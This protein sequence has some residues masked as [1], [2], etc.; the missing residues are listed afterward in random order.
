MNKSKGSKKR[1]ESAEKLSKQIPR[2]KTIALAEV[3]GFPS[4]N[5]EQAKKAFRDKADFIYINK[6]VIYNALKKTSQELADKVYL[7]K[8][9]VLVLS[10]LDAFELARI[11][12][13][14]KAYAK[15]K[16]GEKAPEDIILPSGPTP[17]PPGPML[18]Q[19]SS[20]GVKTKNEG[21]KISI[22]ADT[23]VVKKGDAVSDKIAT[24]LSS[25]E[26]RPKELM[27][28]INYA[29]NDKI[30]FSKEILYKEPGEYLNELAIAF[31][32]SLSLSVTRG[33]LNR[34]S[35][36]PLIKKIYIGVRF[37]SVDRNIVS[38]STIKDILAK[39]AV[40]AGALTKV[41]GGK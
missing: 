9:P 10:N 23:T 24:I 19:F 17:F 35:I 8:M 15:L 28:S 3:S 25:M 2:Y 33:I 5:F 18:S 13:E 14:N 41:T 31:K 39:A 27:L 21:G 34:Y 11:A 1:E 26:I 6:V 16:E 29:L 30:L 12:T 4:D 38:K 32:S 22:I 20:I 40:Q 36:K 7:T 37:L